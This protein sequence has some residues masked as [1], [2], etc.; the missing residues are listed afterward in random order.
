HVAFPGC[1]LPRRMHTCP[2][3]PPD[4]GAPFEAGYGKVGTEEFEKSE[5]SSSPKYE[6]RLFL[7]SMG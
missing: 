6:K 3:L 4:D 2:D 7:R 1:G 5:I